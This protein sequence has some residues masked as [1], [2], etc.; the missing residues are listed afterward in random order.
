MQRRVRRR[1]GEPFWVLVSRPADEPEP[2]E[3]RLNGQ[4]EQ[5]PKPS[6]TVLD[7]AAAMPLAANRAM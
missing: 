3:I 7:L 5:A 4:A 6:P 2:A 1:D